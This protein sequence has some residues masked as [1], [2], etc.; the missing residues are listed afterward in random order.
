M[1]KF[2]IALGSGPRGLG[3]E[4]RYSDHGKA[5]NSHEFG[6]FSYFRL[7]LRTQGKQ[8]GQQLVYFNVHTKTGAG[9]HL[10]RSSFYSGSYPKIHFAHLGRIVNLTVFAPRYPISGRPVMVTVPVP[11]FVLAP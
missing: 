4:S 9:F 8:K 7:H 2:G 10:L 6:A 1:A 11:T 5:L 3:F